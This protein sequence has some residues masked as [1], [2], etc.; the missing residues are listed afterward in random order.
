MGVH[1]HKS[2]H[3]FVAVHAILRAGAVMVPIDPLAPVARVRSVVADAAIEVVITDTRRSTFPTI[4]ADGA[5]R[6]AVVRGALEGEPEPVGMSIVGW[7]DLADRSVAPVAEVAPDDDA[8]VIYTS[9]STGVPKGIVHTHRSALAY[10]RLAAA[11]Y[12]LTATDRLANI[13]SLHFDQSTFELYVAPFVGCGVTVVPD[14]VLRFPASISELI[15][16]ERVTVWYSVPY[17]LRQLVARGALETRDLSSIRWILYGGESFPPGEL[18]AL[19]RAIPTATVSNVYG[20]AEV[21]QCMRHDLHGPP[22]S[23]APIPIGRAWDDTELVV[24]DAAG[25]VLDP[26]VAPGELWVATT[27]M[28]DR[29]W[30]RTDLT[31][32]GIVERTFPDRASTRWYRTGDLVEADLHGDLVFLGRVDN[33]V[34]IRGQRVELEAIDLT[35]REIEGVAEVATVVLDLPDGRGIVAVVEL[36]T[37]ADVSLRDVQRHVATRHARVAVPLDLVVAE[38]LVRT[39]TSKVDRNAALED[40][41][42]RTEG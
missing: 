16:R 30:N 37:G 24:V 36:A 9:G 7:S 15:E 38:R 26:A 18:A 32:A 5:L 6:G 20:P 12:A 22:T 33:Q 10:V 13:A 21:N 14:A 28:M 23:D 25:D 34:K 29:Y 8:Y 35:I 1:L 17:V 39:A 2:V 40:A 3:S 11:A 42:A 19:M 41:R 27:T 4:V 31:S